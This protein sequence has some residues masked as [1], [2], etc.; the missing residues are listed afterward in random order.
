MKITLMLSFLSCRNNGSLTAPAA[1]PCGRKRNSLHD[2][3]D[4]DVILIVVAAVIVV[5]DRPPPFLKRMA[6]RPQR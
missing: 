2:L 1:W 5:M 4:V 3:H 6:A